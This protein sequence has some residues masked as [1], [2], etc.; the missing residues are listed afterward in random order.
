MRTSHLPL[1]LLRL[2]HHY[3]K[4]DR[5][6][7]ERRHVSY[8]MTAFGRTLPCRG[9]RWSSRVEVVQIAEMLIEAG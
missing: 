5:D 7:K 9:E 4:N 1:G 3:C 2:W 6:K 8:Q